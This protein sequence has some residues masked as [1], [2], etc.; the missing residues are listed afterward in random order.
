MYKNKKKSKVVELWIYINNCRYI[1][2]NN[3]LI[4]K[5]FN[6]LQD[7]NVKKSNSFIEAFWFGTLFWFYPFS[8]TNSINKLFHQL[9]EKKSGHFFCVRNALTEEG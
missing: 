2:E 4:T 9:Y 5:T 1:Y 8:L 6:S 3:T 7:K